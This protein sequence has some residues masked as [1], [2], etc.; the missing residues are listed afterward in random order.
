MAL[1]A[2]VVFRAP[3]REGARS[4][5]PAV[6]GRCGGTVEDAYFRCP[7]CGHALKTHCPACSRVVETSWSFC[8]YCREDVSRRTAADPQ[9]QEGEAT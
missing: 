5:A 8:P 2:W 1:V 4:G 6:C 9:P 7:H 3:R